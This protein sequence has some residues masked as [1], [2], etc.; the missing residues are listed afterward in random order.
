MTSVVASLL[1]LMNSWVQGNDLPE[2]CLLQNQFVNDKLQSTEDEDN[3]SKSLL[4]ARGLSYSD[5]AVLDKARLQCTER[6]QNYKAHAF[7][8]RRSLASLKLAALNDTQD[9]GPISLMALSDDPDDPDDPDQ[10]VTGAFAENRYVST[11]WQNILQM[12]D[13]SKWL[14]GSHVK[15]VYVTHAGTFNGA[16]V[17][18][19]GKPPEAVRRMKNSQN[20]WLVGIWDS[21]YAKM[22]QLTFTVAGNGLVQVH[23]SAARY[24]HISESAKTAG[25]SSTDAM[26]N[27]WHSSHGQHNAG[28]DGCAGYGIKGMKVKACLANKTAI[29]EGAKVMDLIGN[30]IDEQSSSGDACHSQLLEARHQLNQ[31]HALVTDLT[32]ELNSTEEQMMVY[33]KMLEE[34]L[35]EMSDLAKWREDELKKCEDARKK[36]VDMF[37]KLT[38]ELEEMHE[39]ANP[40]VSMDVKDGTLHKVALL[41]ELSLNERLMMTVDAAGEENLDGRDTHL[42]GHKG[43]HLSKAH[44]L[45]PRH[46]KK[47]A[48]TF[49]VD[50]HAKDISL[51]SS[52]FEETKKASEAYHSC[53]RSD[54]AHISLTSNGKPKTNEECEAEKDALEKTYVKAYV[55]LSRMKAEYEELANSTACF[56]SVNEEFNT[57]NPPLQDAADKLSDQINEKIRALQAL[58]PRLD[59]AKTSEEKLRKQVDKVTAQCKH[60]G[61]TVSDLDKVREAIRSLS[62]CPGLSRV[63]FSMPRWTGTWAT[64]EQDAASQD[65]DEQDRLMGQACNKL[66]AGSRAAEVGEIQEQTVEGIPVSNT[67]P[68]ALMGTCPDCAGDK[69]DFFREGHGRVCWESGKSLSLGQR[70]TNCGAGRKA[71]LCVEDRPDIREIPAENQTVPQ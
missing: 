46:H 44:R 3:A 40:S 65:D 55:E 45:T 71:V 63:K 54:D 42:E 68:V 2:G 7:Q 23:Q 33:D 34:K 28:C 12:K 18:G 53:I 22:I 41:Q 17:N 49:D 39:I 32:Q 57:R 1:V 51:V 27:L 37:A 70:S 24:K 43:H 30:F 6:R 21:P 36:A 64:F 5:M 50:K 38:G 25:F 61:A 67:A 9:E 48:P 47:T 19:G 13:A 29:Q 26:T 15:D 20:Q 69:D 60:V 35:R 14:Q 10:C 16:Y 4:Q 58:R 62:S 56:D 31:L 59:G 8:L 52:L 66:K 11:G